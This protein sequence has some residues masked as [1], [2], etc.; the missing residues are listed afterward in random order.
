MPVC[1][2]LDGVR[3]DLVRGPIREVMISRELGTGE[4]GVLSLPATAMST[5]ERWGEATLGRGPLT[6][7][8]GSN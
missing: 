2:L 1:G 8:R 3:V 6:P 7:S 5:L 4:V